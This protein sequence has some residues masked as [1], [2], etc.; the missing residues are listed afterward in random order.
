MG[1]SK[2]RDSSS[3]PPPAPKERKAREKRAVAAEAESAA[4]RPP[5]PP[6]APSVKGRRLRDVYSVESKILGEGHYGKVRR[7]SA[8]AAASKK[9]AVKTITKSR[10]SRPE[11]LKNEI[12]IIQTVRHANIIEVVDIFDE[13]ESARRRLRCAETGRDRPGPRRYLHIVTELCTG[14]ELFDRIIEKTNSSEKHFSE[15]DA[16]GILEQI[17]SAVACVAAR[18]PERRERGAPTLP[19]TGTATASSRRSSTAT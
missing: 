4:D 2:S 12:G 13:K 10:V 8:R 15:A 1:Q 5:A 7:C 17:L 6:R 16:V 3:A 19:R 14:G 11:M 18:A 9:Y